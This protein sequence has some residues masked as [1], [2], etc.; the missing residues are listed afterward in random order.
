M[1]PLRTIT[2]GS[3][4]R[5]SGGDVSWERRKESA[6][7]DAFERTTRGQQINNRPSQE[8]MVRG[9]E[10]ARGFPLIYFRRDG[11]YKKSGMKTGSIRSKWDQRQ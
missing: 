9:H 3:S 4:E 6:T 5:E 7:G 8:V 10:M 2:T 1:C 11:G